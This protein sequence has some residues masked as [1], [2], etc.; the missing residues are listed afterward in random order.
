M[1]WREIYSMGR[2][3]EALGQTAPAQHFAPSLHR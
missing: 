2:P 1:L 3:H